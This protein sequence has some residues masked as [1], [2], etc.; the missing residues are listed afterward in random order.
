MRFM[1]NIT[2]PRPHFGEAARIAGIAIAAVQPDQLRLPTPCDDYDVQALMGHLLA[3]L[4]RITALG[5]GEDPMSVPKVVTAVHPDCWVQAW[6]HA[7]DAANAAW[8]DA[9]KLEQVM[10][11]PWATAPGAAMVAMYTSELSVHTWDLAVTTKQTPRWN[12]SVLEA[13]LATAHQ[14]LPPGDRVAMFEQMKPNLPA[15]L[16]AGGPPFGNPIPIAEDAPLIDRLVA[17]YGH[18]APSQLAG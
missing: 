14:A 18:S 11:L 13:S 1:N 5:N 15:E 12:P 9:A 8:T 10:T 16:A 4:G 6:S 17:F 7:S 2:D 3:V